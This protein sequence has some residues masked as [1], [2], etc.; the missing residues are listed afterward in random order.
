MP[1]R[2]HLGAYYFPFKRHVSADAFGEVRWHGRLNQSR[3][4]QRHN[5][6]ANSYFFNSL[7]ITCGHQNRR[8]YRDAVLVAL[9]QVGVIVAFHPTHFEL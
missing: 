5:A 4:R 7:P 6:F 8:S 3:P 2:V 1:H 9:V